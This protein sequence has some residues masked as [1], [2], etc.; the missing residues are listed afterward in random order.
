MEFF[1]EGSADIVISETH[2]QDLL[3]SLLEQLR[4]RGPLHHVLILP[5]DIT[6]MHSWAGFLTCRLW[7]CLRGA[8][9]EVAILPTTGTHAPMADEEI[10]R[11]FP[12]VPRRLFHVHDWRQ[13]VVSLGEVPA[14]FIHEV[15]QGKLDF[16]V[17][18]EVD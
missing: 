9:A 15:S 12:G 17:R 1:H 18:V 4:A 8:G 11:M 2:A 14:S 13:G 6:R 10:A 3:A 7:E 5:P 16:P